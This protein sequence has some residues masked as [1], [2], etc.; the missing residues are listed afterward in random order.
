MP[1]PSKPPAKRSARGPAKAVS[2]EALIPTALAA[3][4]RAYAPYSK[5]RVGAALLAANGTVYTGCNVENAS[6]GLCICAERSA[7]IRAVQEGQRRF[8]GLVVATQSK[9]PSPP[10]GMCRQTLAEF[11]ADLPILLVNAKGAR[12][13]TSLKE[14]FPHSFTPDFL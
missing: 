13:M 9:Q 8:A 3:R 4:E 10:C 1:A 11:A 5:F 6:Y 2:L 14:I 7:V 12:M